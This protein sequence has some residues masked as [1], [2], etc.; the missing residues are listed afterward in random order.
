MLKLQKWISYISLSQGPQGLVV[1]TG[2]TSKKEKNTKP[3]VLSTEWG[4]WALSFVELLFLMLAE[5]QYSFPSSVSFTPDI[6]LT[7]PCIALPTL[8][9][10]PPPQSCPHAPVSQL[11]ICTINCLLTMSCGLSWSLAWLCCREVIFPA[12]LNSM[13]TVINGNNNNNT[14]SWAKMRKNMYVKHSKE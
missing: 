12:S 14:F 11:P 13:Y 8:Q 3:I 6:I 5:V 4:V 10:S 7:V 2:Q 9:F 1:E